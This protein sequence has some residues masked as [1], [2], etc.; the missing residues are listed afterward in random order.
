M[1]RTWAC[2]RRL[3]TRSIGG[4][5]AVPASS[6]RTARSVKKRPAQTPSDAPG[7]TGR[8]VWTTTGR[9]LAEPAEVVDHADLVSLGQCLAVCRG[10]VMRHIPGLCR[11]RCISLTR[12][13]QRTA[14]A[15]ASCGACRW[16]E[17]S[18]SQSL[19]TWSWSG[20]AATT[21]QGGD[22]YQFWATKGRGVIYPVLVVVTVR[23]IGLLDAGVAVT[24]AVSGVTVDER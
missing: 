22:R 12:Q 14:S 18:T 17:P 13:Q 11:C 24:A 20:V 10:W 19:A 8:T 23:A 6:I 5:D 21:R 7:G 9:L 2:Q 1:R 16:P 3:H 15:A 4:S